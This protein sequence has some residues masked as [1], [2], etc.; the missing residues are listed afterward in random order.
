[1]KLVLIPAGEFLMGSPVGEEGRG[2][3]EHL[4]RVRLTKAFYLHTTEVTQGQWES[5]MGTKPWIGEQYVKEGPDYAASYVSW[6]DAQEF[7]RR[8]SEMDERSYR[9]PTEAEWE[10]ACRAGTT[11]MYHFGDDPSQL[12]EYAWFGNYGARAQEKYPHQVA[13]RKPNAFGLYDMHGN[14]WEWCQDW[15]GD[16][17]HGTSPATDPTGW[18][19]GETRL[20]KGGSWF[21]SEEHSRSASRSGFDP[22]HLFH[23]VMYNSGFRVVHSTG[24]NNTDCP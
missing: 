13:L 1:M 9:L 22:S 15:Y 19:S 4:R 20:L 17:L 7:C 2:R 21:E 11:T 12:A 10:Y 24:F 16:K 6:N 18:P 8:L 23:S 3:D 5:V 14:Q